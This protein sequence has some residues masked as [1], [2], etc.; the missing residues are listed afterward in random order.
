MGAE[1]EMKA[2]EGGRSRLRDRWGDYSAMTIDPIDQCTFYYT[3]EYL[4]TNVA[5]N[6]LRGSPATSSPLRLG[7][8]FVRHSH[9]HHHF[10]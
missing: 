3:N 8:E 1:I 10:G 7:R 6:C 9:R 4:K 5:F 2:G